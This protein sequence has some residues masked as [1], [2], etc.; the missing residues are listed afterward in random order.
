MEGKASAM[1][2]IMVV[3]MMIIGFDLV[4]GDAEE[5]YANCYLEYCKDDE[6]AMHCPENC[7]TECD[8]SLPEEVV[9]CN[10]DCTE[11]NCRKL[12]KH[13]AVVVHSHLLDKGLQD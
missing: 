10:A 5:C 9:N 12:N 1:V 13:E 8:P 11:N 7:I 2:V 6:T 3:M 4:N